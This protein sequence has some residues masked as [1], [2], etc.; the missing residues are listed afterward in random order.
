M[1]LTPID[2][3][4][5]HEVP[6]S[7]AGRPHHRQIEKSGRRAV[8]GLR[9]RARAPETRESRSTRRA[10]DASAGLRFNL[11]IVVILET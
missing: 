2:R 9:P 4:A 10:A 6:D 5:Y 8:L 11:V 7:S 3:A 1:P